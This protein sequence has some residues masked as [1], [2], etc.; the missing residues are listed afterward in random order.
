MRAV[1][2]PDHAGL[3]YEVWADVSGDTGKVDD[4]HLDDWLKGLA[5]QPVSPDYHQA[6]DRWQDSFVGSRSRVIEMILASRLLVGHGNGSATDVGL[7]LHRTWGVPMIPGSALK[8]L[9]AQYVETLYGPAVAGLAPDRPDL[10]E[11]NKQRAR[12]QGVTWRD[13][14]ILFGPG[15]VYRTLFGSSDADGENGL[16]RAAAIRG[17]VVFH[18]ALYVPG[19]APDD[20]PLASDVLTVHQKSYYD[21]AGQNAPS[22]YDDPH[23]VRFLSVRPKTSFLIALSGPSDWTDFAIELLKRA[24]AEWGVGGKTSLGYGRASTFRVITVRPKVTSEIVAS[25]SAWLE[26]LREDTARHRLKKVRTEWLDR[27]R[28]LSIAEREVAADLIRTHVRRSKI[29]KETDQLI[30]ELDGDC[31]PQ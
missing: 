14:R 24:L 8:G 28:L 4:Q 16:G 15:E 30:A 13:R 7:T 19:S 10:S 27:L 12:Y 17:A 20:K 9:L 23:P 1:G 25:F 26:G 3:A 5:G 31:R 18:D 2:I 29:G 11:E 22:D 21:S 6:F